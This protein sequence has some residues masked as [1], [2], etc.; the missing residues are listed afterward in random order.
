MHRQHVTMVTPVVKS[1][2]KH[3]HITTEQP[4]ASVGLRAIAD[5]LDA[6][7]Q[8]GTGEF[9]GGGGGGID[10]KLF[11]FTALKCASSGLC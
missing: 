6:G 4:S 5:V 11:L 9:G 7:E 3:I 2:H 10:S 1:A 8:P